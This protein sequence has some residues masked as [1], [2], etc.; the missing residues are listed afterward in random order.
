MA[1]GAKCFPGPADLTSHTDL[2]GWAVLITGGGRGCGPI[3]R[4]AQIQW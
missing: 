1:Q 2:K 3:F 4:T